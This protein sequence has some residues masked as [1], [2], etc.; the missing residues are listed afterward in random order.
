MVATVDRSRPFAVTAMTSVAPLF[1]L[2]AT[3]NWW[4]TIPTVVGED[5][6]NANSTW[7]RRDKSTFSMYD[8]MDRFMTGQLTKIDMILLVS[9]GVVGME[10]ANL[11]SVYSGGTSGIIENN[12]EPQKKMPVKGVLT[13]FLPVFVIFCSLSQV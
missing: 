4:G 10:V 13:L 9:L 6:T 3:L 8:F 1:F 2:V 5:H 11:L 7:N 12:K